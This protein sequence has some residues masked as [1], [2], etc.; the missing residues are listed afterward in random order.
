MDLVIRPALTVDGDHRLVQALHAKLW[1]EDSGTRDRHMDPG[2]P[3]REGEKYFEVGLADERA[4]GWL[5]E[6]GGVPVGFL[7]ARLRGPSGTRPVL[8]ADLESMYVDGDHR[9]SG[10]GAA[11][12]A[13]FRRWAEE[14]GAGVLAVSAY[15]TNERAVAFYRRMGFSPQSVSMEQEVTPPQSV[16]PQSVTPQS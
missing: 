10:V 14:R 4:A 9:A 3:A 13:T 8:V 12:F 1:R 7:F 16:T 5:A 2:W 11:L 15:A 6:V